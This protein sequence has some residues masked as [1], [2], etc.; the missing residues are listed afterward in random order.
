MRGSD[1][2]WIKQFNEINQHILEQRQ[3]PEVRRIAGFQVLK[4]CSQF[5]KPNIEIWSIQRLYEAGIAKASVP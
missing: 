5:G 4:I 3:T 2:I 1:T